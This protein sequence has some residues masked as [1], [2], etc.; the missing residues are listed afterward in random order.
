[1]TTPDEHFLSLAIR[2]AEKGQY[3]VHPNPQVGCVLVKDGL[4]IGSG[5]HIKAGHGHAEANALQAAGQNAAGAT[6]YVTLEPCSF[7]GRTP[8][9]AMALI[10]AGVKRVVVASRDPHPR[11]QGQGIEMLKAAGI[12]VV[13]PMLEVSARALNPGHYKRY[14]QG[15]PYVRLKL[16]MSLDGK[17][18]LANGESKWITSPE[19]RMDVQ[20]L[21][22]RGSAIVT[23]VQTV[24]DDDPGFAVRRGELDVLHLEEALS[25]E[26]T[27]YVLDPT[28]RTPLTSKLCHQPGT[29]LVAGEGAGTAQSGTRVMTMPLNDHGQIQLEPLLRALALREHS[30]VLFECGRT[31][32]ASLVL[33]RLVDEI[34]IYVAPRFMGADAKSLLNLPEIDRM[35]DLVALEISE[36]RKIG[37]DLRITVNLPLPNKVSTI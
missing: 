17:T 9:C 28:L 22:A 34:V 19:A 13:E 20:K 25:V 26:R 2:L 10:A 32:A 14:E 23:G 37:P 12:E 29:V 36:V 8:S 3:S 33:S 27:V 15:L 11:N 30:E 35:A 1:M 24:V 6:A 7:Q 5:Y 18:A 21:R 16:G 31:L 4:V